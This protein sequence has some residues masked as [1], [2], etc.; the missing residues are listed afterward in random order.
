MRIIEGR[1]CFGQTILFLGKGN[2]QYKE[3]EWIKHKI[4]SDKEM[5]LYYKGCYRIEP[6]ENSRDLVL[7]SRKDISDAIK[8]LTVE[9]KLYHLTELDVDRIYMYHPE[10]KQKQR[11]ILC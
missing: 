1:T 4:S 11:L 7:I 3:T 10:T 6:N 9:K 5:N 8:F 2:L